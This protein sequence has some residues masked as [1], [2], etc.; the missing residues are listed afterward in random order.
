ML[1]ARKGD[2]MKKDRRVDAYIARAQPFA[3]PILEHV[4]A[5]V[6]AA[7]PDA[8]ETIK[9]GMPAFDYNGPLCGMAA[10]QAHCTFGFWKHKLIPGLADV[11]AEKAMGQFGRI[12][13]LRDLPAK[14]V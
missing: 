8:A 9:W 1:A 3:R 10:F 5:L 11:R 14:R 12:A 4:R 7:C 13:S 6:H 2:P